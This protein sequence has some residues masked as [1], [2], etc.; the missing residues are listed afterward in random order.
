MNKL[1]ITTLPVS[2]NWANAIAGYKN[3]VNVEIN[4]PL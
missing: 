2:E 3:D 4:I 1:C